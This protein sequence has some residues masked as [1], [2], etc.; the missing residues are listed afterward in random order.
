MLVI[1]V[2]PASLDFTGFWLSGYCRDAFGTLVYPAFILA[3]ESR[4]CIGFRDTRG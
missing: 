4:T 1:L 3:P 2:Y